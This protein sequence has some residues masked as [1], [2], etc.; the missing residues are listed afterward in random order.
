[1]FTS[2]KQISQTSLGLKLQ[3][4]SGDAVCRLGTIIQSTFFAQS[5]TTIRLTVWKWSGV[6]RYPEALP[7]VL[8]NVRR[9]FPPDP[10]D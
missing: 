1:M 9:A 3:K 6:G 4:N 2:E 7:L 5:G 8:E 10:G